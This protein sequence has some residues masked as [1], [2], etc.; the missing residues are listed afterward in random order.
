MLRL[1]SQVQRKAPPSALF[2]HTT[3]H[4]ISTGNIRL[5]A[6]KWMS[7]PKGFGKF[8]RK[9]NNGGGS[10]SSAESAAGTSAKANKKTTGT[11]G[12]GGTGGDGGDNQGPNKLLWAA[13]GLGVP[14]A[15]LVV[16]SAAEMYN[17]K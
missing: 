11:R 5:W 17:G 14:I 4:K 8:Y 16:L 15:F 13:L 7:I 6:E 3:S 9:P 12:T 10:A 1:A 2:A